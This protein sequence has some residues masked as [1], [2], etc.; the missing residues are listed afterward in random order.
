MRM[1]EIR[2]KIEQFQLPG[3]VDEV[4]PF[5][6]GHINDT[7]LCR[8]VKEDAADIRIIFQ[9][10]NHEIFKKPEELMENVLHV[11]DFLQRK[12]IA[13]GGDPTRETLNVITTREG[14]PYYLDAEGD[15][16]RAYRFIEDATSY[17]TVEKPEDFYACAKTFGNFQRMLA[18]YPADT[19]YETIPDFHDTRLR[20]QRFVETVKEDKAGRGAFAQE[21]IRFILDRKELAEK[22]CRL[23]QNKELPVRVTHNDTKLNNIMIDNQSGKAICVIDLD[24]VMPGLSAYDFGDAIRFGASTGAEDETDL[25]KVRLDLYL[26]EQYVKGFIEGCQGSLTSKELEMLPLGALTIT[27]E[28]AIRFLGD[29]LEGDVYYK[30]HRKNHNLDRARTQIKLVREMENH[31]EEMNG[32]V[33]K[34]LP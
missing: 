27:L 29:H 22:L 21:E 20:F 13:A 30:I 2:E 16:W 17:E 28:Q 15:Y 1:E 4:K 23:R 34:Y 3:K 8:I 18:D 24:T 10:M 31:W 7:Y 25:D 33:R 11:T 5:G 19:L 12:I 14:K 6:N 9:R 32:I 26:Y